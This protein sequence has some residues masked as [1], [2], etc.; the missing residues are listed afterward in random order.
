MENSGLLVN[1]ALA[2]GTA[3][4]G[5]LIAV[6]L[7]QS[8]T[9][10]YILAGI[11]IG[12]YT[13]GFVGDQIA[14][15]ELANVGVILLMFAI[16]VQLSLDDLKRVGNV[17]VF[18]GGLQVLL[19]IGAGTL[20]GVALGWTW[21]EALFFGSVLSNSSSTVLSKVLAERGEPDSIPG[22]MG[23]AW[24]TVQDLSTIVLVVVLTALHEGGDN[25][26]GD[27]AW[28]TIKVALFLIL[29]IPIGSRVLPWVF[30]QVAALRN[31]EVFI[32]TVAAVAI[33]TAYLSSLFGLSVA[34]GAFVAGVVISESEL[35]HQILGDIA[36]L[37]DIFAGLFFVSVG[38][39]VDP[40]FVVR[41][42]PLVALTVAMIVVVKGLMCIGIS[43]AFGYP[44][45][46]AILV[47]AGL[48]QSAEF[49][50]LLARV[51]ANINAI[52]G[53]IFSLML[54]GAAVSIALSPLMHS[55][56][57]RAVHW[58]ERNRPPSGE[59][60]ELESHRQPGPRGHAVILGYG[61]VGR[62]IG[63]SLRRRDF[64]MIVV[65]QD[66]RIVRELRD[67]GIPALAGS[68]DHPLLIQRVNL[69]QARVLV[70]AV[71]DALTARRI[72]DQAREIAPRLAIV[73][74]THTEAER[75]WHMAH[76]ATEVIHGELELAIEMTRF[77]LHRFGVPA[78]ETSAIMQ[79]LRRQSR[80]PAS[81]DAAAALRS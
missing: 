81:D 7:K 21:I 67:D 19:M 28:A 66:Q 60:S 20:V 78:T 63:E 37:R 62:V 80:R 8:V 52:S 27:L 22:Q 50:F 2:L 40:G 74:R 61:R 46:I 70:V 24:S 39:L 42:L 26:L 49:S 75:E 25:L 69:P 35:S 65:E 56:G 76:G 14:V 38:I 79:R 59:L 4:I 53:E 57:H 9:L 31:R 43:L 30:E 17:A 33:G 54:A 68:A 45:R 15:D 51:G 47:G 72:V 44:M 6:R 16:G 5:A 29:L 48:A 55:L 10:G 73:V 71:P 23:I 3:F 34:I 13:P 32:L 77:A 64:P 36:P 58:W 12:P 1:L 18:G 41:N 11:V